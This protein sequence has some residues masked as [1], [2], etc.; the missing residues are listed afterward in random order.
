MIMITTVMV[1]HIPSSQQRLLLRCCCT[2]APIHGALVIQSR[3]TGGLSI[4]MR[5]NI[6][7][8]PRKS[9]LAVI[10]LQYLVQ[11]PREF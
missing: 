9:L 4:Y 10:E 8:S 7:E 3:A 2:L 5:E 6:L 11:R 1:I